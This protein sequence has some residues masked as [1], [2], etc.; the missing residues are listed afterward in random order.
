IGFEY[1]AQSGVFGKYDAFFK[2]LG[3]NEHYNSM[4][5]GVIDTRDVLYFL[6]TIILFNLFTRLVL[7]SRKW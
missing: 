2:N 6:S 7:E 5:R 3:I 4:S 1:I